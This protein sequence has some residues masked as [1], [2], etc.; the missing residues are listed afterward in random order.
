MAGDELFPLEDE[1]TVADSDNNLL[2]SEEACRFRNLRKYWFLFG[3]PIRE[4]TV[5]SYV[6]SFLATVIIVLAI[7][8]TFSASK[9]SS[10]DPGWRHH[11]SNASFYR[12]PGCIEQ[13][14]SMLSL[15]NISAN[16]WENFYSCACSGYD[17]VKGSSG[18]WRYGNLANLEEY[19]ISY[20][21]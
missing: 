16:A 4:R 13:T 7:S 19:N 8:W 6:I 15:L 21:S 2:H 18:D 20:I 11:N 3:H 5:L 1:I 14:A 12:K 10:D 9:H 17:E